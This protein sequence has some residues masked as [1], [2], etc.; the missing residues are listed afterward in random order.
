LKRVAPDENCRRD[1]LRARWHKAILLGKGGQM[2]KK[3]GTA[4]RLDIEKW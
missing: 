4:A 1:L 2:L 3:I